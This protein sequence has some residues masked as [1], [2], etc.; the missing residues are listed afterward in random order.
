MTANIR[1]I[2][3]PLAIVL[4]IFLPQF[5]AGS[6]ILPFLIGMMMFLTFISKIPSQEH[7]FTFRIEIRAL[8]LGLFL[9]FLLFILTKFFNLPKEFLLA[10]ILLA[11]SPPANAAPAMSKILGGNPVLMLKIFIIGHVIACFSIPLVF[12]YFSNTYS[13]E[14]YFEMAKAI[15]NKMQPIVT[16]PLALAFGMRIFNPS[17]A[18]KFLRFQKYTIF[19]WTFAVFLIISNAS[20]KIQNMENMDW[21]MFFGMGVLSLI[22]CVL[23]FVVGWF[24]GKPKHPIEFSQSLGQKNTVLIIILAQTFAKEMPLVV[25]GPIWYVVWQNLVLS[26]MTAKVKPSKLKSE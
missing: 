15:F 11:L 12:G 18:D 4:G 1:S 6:D 3:M 2:L 20:Y 22:F 7:H 25:L 5:H 16:I 21:N 24:I 23:L 13:L 8:V 9:T 10:G 14:L 26:F 19:I 17:F